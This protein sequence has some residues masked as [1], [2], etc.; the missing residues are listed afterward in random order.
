MYQA[1]PLA[2]RGG[3]PVMHAF[4]S[5][6]LT[7]YRMYRLPTTPRFLTRPQLLTRV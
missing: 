1:H 6:R 4:A 2:D 7:I 5:R 3:T